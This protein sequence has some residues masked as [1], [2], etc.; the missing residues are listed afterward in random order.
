MRLRIETFE[1]N[2]GN[3]AAIVTQVYGQQE[4]RFDFVL[5]SLTTELKFPNIAQVKVYSPT[6]NGVSKPWKGSI[7]YSTDGGA[8]YEAL[9]CKQSNDDRN[10]CKKSSTST[11]RI[12][13]RRGQ[14]ETDDADDIDDD[15]SPRAECL[16]S[17]NVD[18]ACVL[19]PQ[20][21]PNED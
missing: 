16:L 11:D 3:L 5:S 7:T 20:N 18:S 4:K 19:V 2:D 6:V 1:A 14:D 13:V 12:L 17:T 15:A 10:G 9:R 8:S 21:A